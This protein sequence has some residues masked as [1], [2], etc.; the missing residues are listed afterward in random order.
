MKRRRRNPAFLGLSPMQQILVGSALGVA[1][2]A[3]IAFAAS[4]PAPTTGYNL[5]L[6]PLPSSSALTNPVVAPPTTAGS[7]T[8]T[9]TMVPVP[10]TGPAPSVT[11]AQ[12]VLTQLGYT[13]TVTQ[14]GV[15]T[16]IGASSTIPAMFQ[17]TNVTGGTVA[18]PSTATNYTT[19][20]GTF[21]VTFTSVS[22][23]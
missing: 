18:P 12:S 20:N 7:L 3:G 15:Y 13:A 2:V 19:P 5:P 23:T 16:Q 11:D 1:T 9:L 10:S 21:S 8:I 22:A 14:T 6:I 4:S 17:A